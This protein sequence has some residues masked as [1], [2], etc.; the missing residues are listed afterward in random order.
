M[1][2][3]TRMKDAQLS[4]RAR[5]VAKSTSSKIPATSVTIKPAVMSQAE[6]FAHCQSD[7]V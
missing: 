4:R 7:V 2:A 3:A 5:R 6:K 1:P